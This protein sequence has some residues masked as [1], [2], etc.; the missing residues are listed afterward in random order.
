DGDWLTPSNSDSVASNSQRTETDNA[1]TL[2]TSPTCIATSGPVVCISVKISS[3]LEKWLSVYKYEVLGRQ[4]AALA[5]K[6]LLKENPAN[7]FFLD[8]WAEV[9]VGLTSDEALHLG[10]RHNKN[11]HFIHKMTHRI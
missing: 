1:E 4:H 9:Y 3:F 2:I 6:D 7:S 11:G 8:V 5:K 10:S